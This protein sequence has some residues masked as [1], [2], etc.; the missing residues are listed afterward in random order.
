MPRRNLYHKRFYDIVYATRNALVFQGLG[1][2]KLFTLLL[3]FF[4]SEI[5]TRIKYTKFRD[6]AED[7]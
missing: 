2:Y 4:F 6:T 3:F 7:Y 5:G 1:K